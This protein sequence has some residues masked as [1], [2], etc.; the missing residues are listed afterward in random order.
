[1]KH[2]K[3]IEK[4]NGSLKELA[5]DIVDLDYDVLVE[6]FTILKDDFAKD[7]IH[8]LKLNHTQVAERLR[9]IAQGLKEILETDIQPLTDIC[10]KFNE[11]GIR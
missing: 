1:M 6:F 4:Y 9:N 10:K 5:R 2:W 7:A 3:T 8:D 11:K